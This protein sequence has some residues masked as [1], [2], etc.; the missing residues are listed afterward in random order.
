MLCF[1]KT[2]LITITLKIVHK[3]VIF[4]NAGYNIFPFSMENSN[5][6]EFSV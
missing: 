1:T 5:E 3:F 4:R 2:I 6:P